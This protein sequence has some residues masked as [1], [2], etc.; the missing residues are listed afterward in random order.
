MN[1]LRPRVATALER[2]M[3][4]AIFFLASLASFNTSANDSEEG[5]GLSI[6]LL[7]FVHQQQVAKTTDS[8]GDGVF[9]FYD[10]FIDDPSESIDT[11]GDGIGN[12]ADDDDDGD[13]VSDNYDY[14][15]LEAG[16]WENPH[17]ILSADALEHVPMG[18]IPS[19]EISDD[20]D[21]VRLLIQ[22]TYG[23]SPADLSQLRSTGAEAWFKQQVE[24]PQTSWLG[25]HRKWRKHFA[26]QGITNVAVDEE[27]FWE[28]VLSADDQLR[29]RM[30][31]VWSQ[32]FVISTTSTLSGYRE[33][34]HSFLDTL[35]AHAFGNFRDLLEAVTKHAA[36]GLY[37]NTLGNE[38]ENPELNIRPDENFARE[39]MQLFTIGLEELNQDGTSKLDQ[40]GTV[41]E[42]YGPETIREYAKV[43]T[44]WHLRGTTPEYWPNALTNFSEVEER[45]VFPMEPVEEYHQKTEKFLLRDYYIPPGQSAE[46]DLQIAIDSLFYHPNVA[47]FISKFLI[48]RLTTSNPS[49]G[50]IG[51]VAAVFNNDGTGTRGD[52]EAVLKAVLFDEEARKSPNQKDDAFGKYKEPLLKATHTF[53]MFDA[54]V[55]RDGHR[56]GMEQ[57]YGQFILRSP[58]VF[59]FFQSDFSPVGQFRDQDL[60]APELQIINE[61][62]IIVQLNGITGIVRQGR[63][64]FFANF[65]EDC[66]CSYVDF[67]REVEILITG[68]AEALV[69]HLLLHL[70]SGVDYAPEIE[71]ILL[72]FISTQYPD[73]YEEDFG[74]PNNLEGDDKDA[75]IKIARE[76]V[77]GNLVLLILATP[78]F[79]IQR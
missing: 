4:S 16:V 55:T 37:L 13:G 60:V 49:S 25:T 2:S 61:G 12:N 20:P 19:V 56:L 28:I 66:A 71:T 68:G 75:A 41:F 14:Q 58:S 73:L 39:V 27:T 10:A 72:D 38:K 63:T 54:Q 62:T 26:E 42:T 18:I 34:A 1:L 47:P 3:L 17:E 53:R 59:N 40:S 36:M 33:A 70:L 64:G 7:A 65:N 79:S 45:A 8:D 9:D 51:R 43:F 35:G 24:L 31:F 67:D 6:V 11:D 76:R 77:V 48:Q 69:S 50:Y 15:P 78:E 5:S 23:P 57:G 44:G 74:N 30:I 29:Q 46:E 32:L 22:S 52:L 21:G